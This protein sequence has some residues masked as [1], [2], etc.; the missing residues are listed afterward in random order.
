MHGGL[1]AFWYTLTFTLTYTQYII[2]PCSIF[3][4]F[5]HDS[6]GCVHDFRLL[7]LRFPIFRPRSPL[8]LHSSYALHSVCPQLPFFSS[9]VVLIKSR[10]MK[11]QATP[12]SIT[13]SVALCFCFFHHDGRERF[14]AYLKCIRVFRFGK[15][16]DYNE[17]INKL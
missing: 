14:K 10:P 7:S 2:P 9:L 17:L 3:T 11:H 1:Q 5:T 15:S 13:N 12:F 4:V 6:R 8:P 16:G